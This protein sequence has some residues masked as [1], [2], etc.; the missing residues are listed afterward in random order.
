MY[1]TDELCDHRLPAAIPRNHQ[2]LVVKRGGC[3]FSR[4]LA[5]IP[6]YVPS[7]LSLQL[8]I[9][10][11]FGNDEASGL[12]EDALIRPLLDEHQLTGAGL[13]RRNPIPLVMVSGAQKAYEAL[14]NARGIGI[15][16]RYEMRTQGIPIT[17]LIIL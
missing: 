16:R 8:V 6:A 1:V 7:P 4:K 9:I 15:K 5:N 12:T 10:I 13:A 3:P 17:N 14:K 11:S 2:V